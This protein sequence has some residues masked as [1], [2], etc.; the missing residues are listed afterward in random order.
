MISGTL[1]LH[2]ILQMLGMDYPSQNLFILI[3]L[4]GSQFIRGKQDL[5]EI[6]DHELCWVKT[7]FSISVEIL[8]S[9]CFLA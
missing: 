8:F 4:P 2:P 6:L 3:N 5:L 9:N 7:L 1:K